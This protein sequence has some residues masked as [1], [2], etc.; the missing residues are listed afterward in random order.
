MRP[1][2]ANQPVKK[3]ME[4]FDVVVVGGGNAAM[5][6]ALSARESVSRVLCLE[7]APFDE[8]GGNSKFTAGAMRVVYDGVDDLK[9][10]M[11]D[12]TD[13]ESANTDFGT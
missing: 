2:V 3:S 5:C 4:Q 10:L 8:A 13:Q 12:H 11:P 1:V 7:R 9:R 6:A